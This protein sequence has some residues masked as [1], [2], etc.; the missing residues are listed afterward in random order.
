MIEAPREQIRTQEAT[1]DSPKKVIYCAVSIDGDL[2]VGN[3]QQQIEGVQAMRQAHAELDILGRTSW[4][5][6]ENDF[7]WT[8]LYPE[9]LVELAES[10]ECIGIHD[11]LDTHYLENKSYELIYQFISLSWRRLNEFF[12]HSG[13]KVQI[14]AHRNGSVHQGREIYRAL[15]LMGYTILSDVWPG[16]KWYSRV[17]PC[18][19]SLQ[20]WKSLDDKDDPETIFTDNSRVPLMAVPWRHDDHNWL[21]VNSTSGHFLHVPV[22]C[23]PWVER[24]RV[25]SAVENSGSQV[26]LV[27]DTHPYNLQNPE[28]GDVSIELMEEYCNS[29]KWIRDT[30]QAIFIRFDQIPQLITT[31]PI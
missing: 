14:L 22:T 26:F 11:H 9:L 13:V 16:K 5:I 12:I 29:L 18:E 1:L 27:I 28:T 8:Q 4:L 6:N 31:N 30:Y 7:H 21:D 17:V 10:G 24:P 23:L 25:Q 15:E 19:H 2:R 3:H 20:P